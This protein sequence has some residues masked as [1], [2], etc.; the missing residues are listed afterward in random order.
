M[1]E[2]QQKINDNQLKKKG[3]HYCCCNHIFLV[4]FK[5]ASFHF[6]KLPSVQPALFSSFSDTFFHHILYSLT[7]SPPRPPPCRLLIRYRYTNKGWKVSHIFFLSSTSSGSSILLAFVLLINN[8]SFLLFHRFSSSVYHC[9]RHLRLL[10]FVF[11]F[12]Y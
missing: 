10:Q 1:F 3:C 5:K 9:S 4:V 7:S 12:Y 2:Q 8:P 6:N 11:L